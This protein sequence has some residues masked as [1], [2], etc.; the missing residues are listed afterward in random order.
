M[1]E[2]YRRTTRPQKHERL[3]AGPAEGRKTREIYRRTTRPRKTREICRGTTRQTRQRTRRSLEAP[4]GHRQPADNNGYRERFTVGPPDHGKCERLIVGPPETQKNDRITTRP[5]E[6]RKTRE[7]HRWT[8]RPRKTREICRGTTEET[9]Q[10][11]GRFET[12]AFSHSAFRFIC[13]RFWAWRWAVY[14]GER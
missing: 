10:R 6:G 4:R 11:R 12:T 14:M 9:Q 1:R 2:I 7:L 3:N 13:S 5:A 8:T